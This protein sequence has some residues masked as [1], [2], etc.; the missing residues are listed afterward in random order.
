[1]LVIVGTTENNPGAETAPPGFSTVIVT[2]PGAAISVAVTAAVSCV[3][4]TKLVVRAELPH[5]TTDPDTKLLPVTVSVKDDPPGG[6]DFGLKSFTAG[7]SGLIGKFTPGEETVPPGLPTVIT[8]LLGFAMKLEGTTAVNCV[9]LTKVV[10]SDEPAQITTDPETKPV[11]V[12]VRLNDGPPAIAN[13]GLRLVTLG[14]GTEGG[15]IV[16]SIIFEVK[17]SGFLTMMLTLAGEAINVGPTPAINCDALIKVVDSGPPFQ[18][19]VE[20]ETKPLPPT[21]SVTDA[22]PAVVE[23]GFKDVITCP[24]SGKLSQ[25]RPRIQARRFLPNGRDRTFSYPCSHPSLTAAVQVDGSCY[26][27]TVRVQES[28]FFGSGPI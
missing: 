12:T 1:M 22:P 26:V 19:T 21:V 3:A 27:T 17:P 4:L 13:V 14:T 6:A 23:D 11:P 15:V 18:S 5:I 16:K 10:V 24:L 25:T 20:P 8:V 7:P 2:S 28:A 9:A